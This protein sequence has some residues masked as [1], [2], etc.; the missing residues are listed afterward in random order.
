[1]NN[2]VDVAKWQKMTILEQMGN[3][4]SEVGRAISAH[5]R[6]DKESE[7][8]AIAR[9]LDLFSATA[10]GLARQKSPR[11]R[12]ALRAKEQ[13]LGLFFADNFAD[14]PAIE[15]YFMQFA[16]AARRDR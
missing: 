13:F 8:G 14:S 12:E 7:Q 6:D 1:M 15:N 4:G 11:L 2:H 5:K 3:I 10:D 9:A 16:I